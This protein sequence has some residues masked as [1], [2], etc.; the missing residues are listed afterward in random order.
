MNNFF[1]FEPNDALQS[2]NDDLSRQASAFTGGGAS[3]SQQSWTIFDQ[4]YCYHHDAH[5]A[6]VATD[7]A[8][9]SKFIRWPFHGIAAVSWITIHFDPAKS[10]IRADA[11]VVLAADQH[12]E[13]QMVEHL[14]GTLANRPTSIATTWAGEAKDFPALRR[15]A[16]VHDLRQPPQL[17]NTWTNHRERLDLCRVSSGQ[18]VAVHLPELLA[19]LSIPCKPSPSKSI[20]KLVENGD[21]ARV[22]E[23]V[24]ADTL[25]T[26]ALTVKHLY[27]HGIIDAQPEGAMLAIAHAASDALP[28]SRF[29]NRDFLPWAESK[30]VRVGLRALVEAA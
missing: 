13:R 20:G 28:H 10:V 1:D 18:A 3:N 15:A 23:Q 22:K 7:G 14:F 11:P 6:Y 16:M 2:L 26:A 19:A 25:A 29:I 17:C 24:L 5:A 27:A 21:W 4:E 9:A 30:C 12:S 8:A